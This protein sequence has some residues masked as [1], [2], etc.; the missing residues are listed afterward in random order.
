MEPAITNAFLV[1]GGCLVAI[2]V[3]G[4]IT[5]VIYDYYNYRDLQERLKRERERKKED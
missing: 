2:I 3:L 4:I 1:M 5:C